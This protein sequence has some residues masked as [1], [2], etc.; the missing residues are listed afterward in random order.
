M[1]N[2]VEILNIKYV[3][4][5]IPTDCLFLASKPASKSH[6][7]NLL[8]HS[9]YKKVFQGFCKFRCVRIELFSFVKYFTIKQRCEIRS[10]YVELYLY[11]GCSDSPVHRCITK[12]SFAIHKSIRVPQNDSD[13]MLFLAHLAKGN[14]SF[15]HHLASVVCRPLTFYILIFSSENHQPSE[16]KL[17]RKHLWK[18]L[19]IDCTFCSALLTNM[20]TTGNSCLTK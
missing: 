18:D 20:A 3:L 16:L 1:R 9:L 6:L 4:L 11:Y 10:L 2:F 19:Y 14:V 8:N 13:P 17:G 5:F 7:Q 12:F 15:C